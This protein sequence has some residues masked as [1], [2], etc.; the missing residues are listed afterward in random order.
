[1]DSPQ[2]LEKVSIGTCVTISRDGEKDAWEI[3]GFGESE[4]ALKRIAYNTP[5]AS[6]MMGKRKGEIVYGIISG[7]QT[8]IE[9]LEISLAGG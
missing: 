4:P 7:K 5:I 8:E 9:I 1:M 3:V 6:L 2:N